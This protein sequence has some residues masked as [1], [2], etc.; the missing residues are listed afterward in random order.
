M[1]STGEDLEHSVLKTEHGP[2]LT[3]KAPVLSGFLLFST[4]F[5]TLGMNLTAPPY[6]LVCYR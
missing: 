4:A 2:S 3:R 1:P 5:R 6:A